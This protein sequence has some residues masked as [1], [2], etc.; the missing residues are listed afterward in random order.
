[1]LR[2]SINEEDG[3]LI[4]PRKWFVLF[5]SLLAK[6]LFKRE[7][8]TIWDCLHGFRGFTVDGFKRL[9]ISDMSP[10]IDIEAVC[11]T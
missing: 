7:G 10:S 1:M 4:K 6:I 5:L 8:N 3:N 2:D 11:R 9:S